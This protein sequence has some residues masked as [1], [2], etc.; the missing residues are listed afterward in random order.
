[1]NG[2]EWFGLIV[3]FI[4]VIVGV[5]LICLFIETEGGQGCFAKDKKPK[6]E[7]SYWWE[8]EEEEE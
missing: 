8:E 6:A 5:A 1:M 7:E 4:V 3:G 2:W